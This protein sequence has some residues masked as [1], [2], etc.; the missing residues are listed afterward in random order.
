[1]IHPRVIPEFKTE[2]EEAKWWFEHDEE[3]TDDFEQAIR[4][5]SAQTQSPAPAA[6]PKSAA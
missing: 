1:M 2:A 3:L 5:D 4:A 6:R